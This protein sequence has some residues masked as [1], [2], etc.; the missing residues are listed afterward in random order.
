MPSYSFV[1][2]IV[3]ATSI[4]VRAE[5][6]EKPRGEGP[7][8]AA[9]LAKIHIRLPRSSTTPYVPPLDGE[10]LR[11]E[12]LE[13]TS[14]GTITVTYSALVADE[15][16]VTHQY[17]VSEDDL[18][19]L[20]PEEGRAAVAAATNDANA[21]FAVFKKLEGK[22]FPSPWSYGNEGNSEQR[23]TKLL[24]AARRSLRAQKIRTAPT[25][26]SGGRAS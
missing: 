26:T 22:D 3:L 6:S 15:T 12:K 25:P 5:E 23:F 24:S 11:F 10:H 1:L 17:A 18:I 14:E 16:L 8:L 4:S 7:V 21:R 2:M 9:I 20:L 19:A 13:P